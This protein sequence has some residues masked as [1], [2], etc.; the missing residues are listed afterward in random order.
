MIV[1]QCILLHVAL[2]NRPPPSAHVPFHS[3]DSRKRPYNF[4]Q[5]TP[6]KPYWTFLIYFTAIL[7]VLQVLF[8]SVTA[9]TLMLGYVGLTVEAML[10]IPQ[11]MSNYNRKSCKGFRA[12]VI[13]NWLVGDAFKMWFFF[14]S[15]SGEG[16]VPWAFKICGI[17]QACC[18]VGLGLQWWIYGDGPEEFGRGDP[19]EK[20]YAMEKGPRVGTPVEAWHMRSNPQ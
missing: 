7:A 20:G 4:W 10:P 8:G 11:L 17:F 15:G 5:W 18:D 3:V 6:S 2:E 1:M 16:G 14:A 12:S 13:A 19:I 9:Y